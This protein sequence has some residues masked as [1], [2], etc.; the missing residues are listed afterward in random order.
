[1]IFNNAVVSFFGIVVVSISIVV[2]EGDDDTADSLGRFFRDNKSLALVCSTRIIMVRFQV[3]LDVV[4][5]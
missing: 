5:K 2:A 3:C 1:V 4:L